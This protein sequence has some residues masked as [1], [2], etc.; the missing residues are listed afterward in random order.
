VEQV[1]GLTLLTSI[2]DGLEA[3]QLRE[4]MDLARTRHRS[5]VIALASKV[6]DDK[7]ALLVS[8]SPDLQDK[9]DAG[10]LLKLMAP[11]VDGRGGGKKD[12]AQGGGTKPEGIGAAFSALRA[13]LAG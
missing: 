8:V 3:P 7:V 12:L 1:N 13:H 10:A 2:V 4:M 11:H 9:A 5:A 6:A